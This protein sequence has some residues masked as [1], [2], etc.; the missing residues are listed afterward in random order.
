MADF[1]KGLTGGFQTGLQLGQ[2]LRQRRMEDELAQAYAKPET[3]QGY[4]AETGQQLEELAK[5]GAYD[6]VPQYGP[7]AEGQAQGVFTG[8]R[9]VPKAGLDLQ[10]DMPAAPMAFNPQQVQDYGGRRVAG[11]FN[12]TE[13]RGLQMQEAARVLGSY[14]DVRGAAA[15]QAQAEE[16]AYQARV[17]PL[18]EQQLRGSISGQEQQR[19]LTDI[20]LTDAQRK[21]KTEEANRTAQSL[22]AR[23]SADGVPIDTTAA[24]KIAADTGADIK[25]VTDTVLG[26]YNL[27]K[28][29]ANDLIERQLTAFNKAA[30]GGVESL[31]KYIADRLDPDKTDNIVP[32]IVQGKDGKLRVMYGDNPLP[33]YQAYGDL[34]QL[35]AAFQGNIKR[36][37]L[38]AAIQISTL[39]TQ[40][41]A[42]EASKSQIRV[43]D[44]TI[45]LNNARANQ[46]K[47]MNSALET[48]LKNSQEAKQLQSQYAMLDEDNDP[49]G[50]KRQSLVNQFNMLSAKAG[51]TIPVGGKAKGSVLSEPVEQKKNDDGTYTAFSKDGGRAL[52]NTF[53][54][55]AI[56]LGMTVDDYNRMKADAQKNGV[57]LVTGE[58]NG[59]LVLKFAGIDGN[60]YDSAE[61][62]K[63]AKPKTA[64]KDT[65]AAV[66]LKPVNDEDYR[67]VP[68]RDVS[69][70]FRTVDGRGLLRTPSYSAG[71]QPFRPN[72]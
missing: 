67:N 46:I 4:T 18:Q 12:P 50:S 17:R 57:A 69:Q 72:D 26:Q 38:G 68:T 14:G 58:D 27:T 32:K 11:Q 70:G 16:Q 3:S 63:Y 8:Y 66:G 54:G 21:A 6:I 40:A 19:Q 48:N 15:L 33:G 42:R 9:A 55:E 25:F 20:Q 2:Q 13:L 31:N 41:Q 51:G 10:G 53:N 49:G 23:M 24:N 5:T 22:L 65:S 45:G 7:A 28:A 47:A 62:A 37:P 43:A 52:Y 29:S 35:S 34:N 30:E 64:S 59:R 71:S 61:K 60:Y 44:S 36:D 56:P 1:F 39:E